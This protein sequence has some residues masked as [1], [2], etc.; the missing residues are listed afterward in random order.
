M[1]RVLRDCGEVGAVACAM[2]RRQ[3]LRR[4]P[5]QPRAGRRAQIGLDRLPDE[6]MG[7]PVRAVA[8]GVDDAAHDQA[9]Q[10]VMRPA[11]GWTQDAAEAA[12]RAHLKAELP[13]YMQPRDYRWI[14]EMPLTPNGKIDRVS[15]REDAMA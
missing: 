11:S 10:L 4:A 5:V 15:L 3:R 1:E 14:G 8:I 6:T 2:S 9:I 7:E 13:A 12:V